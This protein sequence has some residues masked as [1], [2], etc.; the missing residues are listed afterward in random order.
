MQSTYK[1]LKYISNTQAIDSF[2]DYLDNVHRPPLRPVPRP[3]PAPV[4]PVCIQCVSVCIQFGAG[5]TV[6]PFYF[7][8]SVVYP[9]S[10]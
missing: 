5:Y 6:Y 2:V 8:V 9:C 10:S 3:L 4:Y 1:H 7:C